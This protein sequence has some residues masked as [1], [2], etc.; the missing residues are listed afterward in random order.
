[1]SRLHRPPSTTLPLLVAV[2]GGLLAAAGLALSLNL[3]SLRLLLAEQGNWRGLVRVSQ[4][5]DWLGSSSAEVVEALCAVLGLAVVALALCRLA[6]RSQ[7]GG[8][9]RPRYTRRLWPLGAA[10]L[11]VLALLLALAEPL[12]PAAQALVGELDRGRSALFGR[13]SNNPG[14]RAVVLP[15]ADSALLAAAAQSDVAITPRSLRLSATFNS[16][17]LELLFVGDAN[18]NASAQLE[19]RGGGHDWREGLPLWPTNDGSGEPGPAFYGSALLLEPGTSYEVRATIQDPDGVNGPAVLS[20][21]ISTRPEDIAPASALAPTHFVR[22]DGNDAN[23]GRSESS[24]WRS[25][26]QAFASAPE[27]A[28]VQVGPGFYQAP[29]APRLQPLTLVAQ[30][31][32]VDDGRN[33]I[34]EG[35]RSI[36]QPSVVS[37]PAGSGEPNA[38]VWQQVSL[39]GPDG[40]SGPVWVWPNSG[41]Q[42]AFQLGISGSPLEQP[43]RIAHWRPAGPEL[44]SPAGWAQRLYNNHSYNYGFYADKQDIYLR[45]PGDQ[46]PNGLYITVLGRNQP[47]HGLAASGPNIRFSGFEIRQFQAG[48]ALDSRSSFAVVDHNLLSGNF[49]GVAING[50]S[51]EMRGEGN[52]G[53]PSDYGSDHLIEYNRVVDANLWS[54]D[55]GNPAIP[56]RFIKGPLRNGD[57]TPASQGRAGAQSETVAISGRGGAHRVVVRFNTIE[58]TFNGISPGYQPDFDRYAGM[59]MDAHDNLL[60]RVADD[61]FEPENQAINLRVWRN[62]VEFTPVV[63]STGPVD[64][65][66]IYFFRNEAWQI[67]VQGIGRDGLGEVGAGGVYFKRSSKGKPPAR[68]F[69]INN[70]LWTDQ[71]DVTGGAPYAAPGPQQERFYLRNNIIRATRYAFE[72]STN[73]QAP[74]WDEDYNHFYTADPQ[75]RG[76]RYAGRDFDHIEQYRQASGQGAHSNLAGDPR[77]ADPNLANP[78]AGDLSL[79]P[80]SPL[81]DAGT[82]VPNIADRPGVDFGGAAPDLGAHEQ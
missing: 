65:G 23:D 26:E 33:P 37:T 41:A 8:V 28:V 39:A 70:T 18:G 58:G 79:P 32:A 69:V 63:L 45:L 30:H 36:I 40:H 14:P 51:A 67:G 47:T 34:N 20:G 71:P 11:L 46:D 80:G 16:I 61:A 1:M 54:D 60:T 48:V 6:R 4:L 19:F 73:A 21:T 44:Q 3:F 72:A 68:V 31:P 43:R 22:A 29:P 10:A 82:V 56:W 49:A 9:A 2:A 24:A 5:H 7:P 35:L 75:G 15:G 53:G 78:A 42:G 55:P 25:L 52:A 59:D 57:G 13:R 76:L 81:V 64:Y 27:G 12:V 38:G 17:G 74:T 50:T 62:R 66:P 77:T